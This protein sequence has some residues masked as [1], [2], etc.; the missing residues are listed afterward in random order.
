MFNE[1]EIKEIEVVEEYNAEIEETRAK[2][3]ELLNEDN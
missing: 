1:K 2:I 3:L